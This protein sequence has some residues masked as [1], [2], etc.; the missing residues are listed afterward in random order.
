MGKLRHSFQRHCHWEACAVSQGPDSPRSHETI[1][2]ATEKTDV[3]NLRIA[4]A[5]E[6]DDQNI[7][8]Y[9]GPWSRKRRGADRRN[10]RLELKT[11][12]AG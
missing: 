8:T 2:T 10:S 11:I 9:Q 3:E 1:E 5:A 12:I 7:K 4:D 6:C